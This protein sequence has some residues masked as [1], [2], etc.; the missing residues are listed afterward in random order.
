V[1][2]REVPELRLRGAAEFGKFAMP[3]AVR[4]LDCT[5]YFVLPLRTSKVR[6]DVMTCATKAPGGFTDEQISSLRA[7]SVRV[8]P[9]AALHAERILAKTISQIYLGEKTGALVAEGHI[10]RGSVDFI[11]A[12]VWFSDLRNFT[13]N[14][15]SHSPAEIVT[16]LNTFFDA[17]DA[18]VRPRGGEI[19]KLMGDAA[20]VVFRRDSGPDPCERALSAA[21]EMHRVWPGSPTG[22]GADLILNSKFGIGLHYGRVIYGNIGAATRLDFTVIGRDVNIASRIS[23]KC[24]DLGVGIACSEEFAKRSDSELSELGCHPLRGLDDCFELFDGQ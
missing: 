20:M 10:R 21:R 1:K 6:N 4:Q 3:A 13:S 17:V 12:A 18:A 15:E 9:Y 16:L 8:T 22:C 24:S 5:D 14:S 7:F 19:L 11:E 23:A 2:E